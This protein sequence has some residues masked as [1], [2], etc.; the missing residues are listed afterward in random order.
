MSLTS[1]TLATV[2]SVV[3]LAVVATTFILQREAAH[4]APQSAEAYGLTRIPATPEESFALAVTLSRKG[5]TTT[6]TDREVLH[7]LRPD[8]AHNSEDLIAVAQV[9]DHLN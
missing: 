4:A 2:L 7:A 3:V 1:I 8:Y 9:C 6:Q 5:V